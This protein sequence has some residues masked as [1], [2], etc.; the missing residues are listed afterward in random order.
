M[1]LSSAEVACPEKQLLVCCSRTRV[2]P[3]V[4]EEILRLLALPLD[5]DVLFSR[6]AENSVV[7]LLSRQLSAVAPFAVP[8]AQLARLRELVR[9]NAIRSLVLTAELIRVLDAFA[10]AGIEAIPYKGPVLAAQAYGEISLREFEDLDLVLRQRDI[11]GA[12]D[13][14]VGLG[15]RPQYPPIFLP[16]A[17]TSLIP[18]EYDYRD[19]ARRLTIELHSELTLRHFPVPPALDDFARRLVPVSLSGHSVRT[20]GPEDTLVFLCVHGSKDFWER[21]LWIAD[22]AE[23]VRSH[24]QLDW[25]GV[26]Q[27]ADSVCAR[28]MLHLGL[29]L[30][31]RLLDAPLPA[32]ILSRA[33]A[34]RVA[35][36]AASQLERPLLSL[37]WPALGARASFRFRRRMVPGTF[38]GWRYALRLATVPAAEDWHAIRLPRPL[39]PLYAALRP[40][41]LLRKHRAG[42]AAEARFESRVERRAP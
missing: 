12:H 14:L 15:Y 28:R 11:A 42:G 31:D 24:P 40:L 20:F 32:A 17:P 22:V 16:H 19:E 13:A 39:A 27:L 3:R 30:A 26:Y 18:G 41:R 2:P 5:W 37:Q 23:F 7:P 6:A 9:A 38:A 29:A 35:A 36:S 21:L 8:P 34:D 1:S 4:A 10:A 25:E 33:R